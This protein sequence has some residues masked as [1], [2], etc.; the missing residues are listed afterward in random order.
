MDP[1]TRGK[2]LSSLQLPPLDSEKACKP[3]NKSGDMNTVRKPESVRMHSLKHHGLWF[4]KQSK[5]DF[6]GHYLPLWLL[7]KQRPPPAAPTSD[8][9][10][11][12][13][14]VVIQSVIMSCRIVVIYP[15]SSS[16]HLMRQRLISG[17]FSKK[18]KLTK[19]KFKIS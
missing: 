4:V 15:D 16:E 18:G 7:A 2:M 10:L 17:D 1:A 12:N 5:H 9:F 14:S 11:K 6:T 8:Q 19:N 3:H 13:S